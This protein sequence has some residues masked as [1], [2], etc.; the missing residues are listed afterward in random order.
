MISPNLAVM[1][2]DMIQT[3]EKMIANAGLTAED[4]V[5]ER[6]DGGAVFTPGPKVQVNIL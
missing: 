4:I 2:A 3:M 5:V 6:E 1:H